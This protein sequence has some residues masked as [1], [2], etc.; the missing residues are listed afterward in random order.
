MATGAGGHHRED[1]DGRHPAVDPGDARHA[2][3]HAT[4][5]RPFD[6][7]DEPKP[8]PR[9]GFEEARRRRPIAERRADLIDTGRQPG[10]EIDVCAFAP[11]LALQLLARD[12]LAR[13]LDELHE[14]AHRLAGQ[15]HPPA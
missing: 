8:P 4:V 7:C 1:R 10:L 3:R 9:Q 14:D 2:A 15:G 12:D 6:G 5:R 13:P 11:D